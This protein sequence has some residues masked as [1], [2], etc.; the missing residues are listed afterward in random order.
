SPR[1][2]ASWITNRKLMSGP[3]VPLRFVG[4]SFFFF[5]FSIKLLIAQSGSPGPGLE[6]GQSTGDQPDLNRVLSTRY[7]LVS[8]RS[9]PCIPA[10]GEMACRCR[11]WGVKY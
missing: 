9:E 1:L 3:R 10:T 5:L 6:S 2:Q 11:R 7:F 8:A 4:D